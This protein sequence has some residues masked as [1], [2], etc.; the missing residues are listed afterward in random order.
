MAAFTVGQIVQVQYAGS[1][2]QGPLNDPRGMKIVKI[3]RKW[4]T[5]QQPNGFTDR[6]C[7]D[8]DDEDGRRDPENDGPYR[9]DGGDYGSP[10]RVWRDEAHHHAYVAKQTAWTRLT[11]HARER[12]S[13]PAHLTT[14]QLEAI[15]NQLTPPKGQGD[16]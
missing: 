6:F 2:H 8:D 12:S 7:V 14:A 11:A 1:R 3:G 9:I 16:D 5:I 4:A 15:A 10:G 13:M